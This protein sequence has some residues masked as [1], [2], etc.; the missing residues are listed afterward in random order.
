[1]TAAKARWVEAMRHSHV[2][3]VAQALGMQT[4]PASGSTGGAIVGCPVCGADLR[5]QKSRDKRGAIGVRPDG[6]GWHCF[7]CEASGDQ[8]DLVALVLGGRR[9]RE[10]N[11][12]AKGNVR[13]WC[14]AFAVETPP[15]PASKTT[16]R[17]PP[18]SARAAPPKPSTPSYPPAED[19][20]ALLA[21]CERV[22]QS[23]DVTS[24][25]RSRHIPPGPVADLDL[26]LALPRDAGVPAWAHV[27]GEPWPSS[28]H[29]LIVPLV[30]AE[31]KRRSVLARSIEADAERKSTPPAGY[32]RKGLVMACPLAR[33]LLSTGSA[34]KGWSGE[35]CVIIA[36]GETDWLAWCTQWG[37][38]EDA[39]AVIGIV[40]GSWTRRHAD[41]LPAEGA[42]IL[43]ATD[44]DEQGDKYAASIVDTLRNRALTVER[45][46]PARDVP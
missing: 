12:S 46:D 31:G 41:R 30:D 38:Y 10:L 21:G 25:L 6:R 27:R 40:S 33:T 5:H 42:R 3:D 11:P 34:P 28:G 45:Y 9:F 1:M 26:A 37:D 16:T 24:Y 4:Q 13:A 15:S 17:R 32:A 39:P 43:I 35:L 29:R 2:L 19:I 36:E 8:I 22:D 14:V 18:P 44:A 23:P 7:Q 20:A